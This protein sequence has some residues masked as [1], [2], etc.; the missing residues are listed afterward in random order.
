LALACDTPI[1]GTAIAIAS[2]IPHRR[3]ATNASY[4]V[5]ADNPGG[6]RYYTPAAPGAVWRGRSP[7]APGGARPPIPWRADRIRR[8][9][10]RRPFG[11]GY[12]PE[13]G[14]HMH[15]EEAT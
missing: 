12:E 11:V 9:R 10:L 7:S 6:R 15:E 1:V 8:E 2:A 14:G 5:F 13:S 4:L 3:A